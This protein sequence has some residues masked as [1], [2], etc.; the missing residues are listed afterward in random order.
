MLNTY[1]LREDMQDFYME[2]C[3]ILRKIEDLME[4]YIAIWKIQ[5]SK[6][7]NSP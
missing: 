5:C 3:E 6:Y 2:N 1:K 7:P 4:G